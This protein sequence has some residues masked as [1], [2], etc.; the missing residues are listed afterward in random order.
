V[1]YQLKDKVLDTISDIITS[2]N[3]DAY[4][5]GGYVRD[6]ILNRPSKDIDIVTVG[7]GIDLAT[8]TAKKLDRSINVTVFKNFGTAMFRYKD[9]EYEFV[10]ARKESYERNSRKPFVEDGTLQDDQNRRDLTINALALSLK[11]SNFGEITDPFNGLDDLKNKIIKTPLDPNITFSDDPLR[12][13]RAIRF[14]SQLNFYIEP[15]TFKAIQV[16]KERINI[17][18]KER[19]AEE[20]NKILLSPKPSIGFKLLEECELLEIIFPEFLKLKGVDSVGTISHKD[21]FYHTLQVVDNISNNTNNLWLRWAALLHDIGKPA[22]KKFV[23]GAWTFYGHEVVGAKM[24]PDIFKRLKLPL[25]ETVKY[26]QKLINLHLR[27]IV[28]SSEEVT[29]SAIRRLLFDA[30]DEVDD[31]MLLCEADITS[32]N[33]EKV[34]RFLENFKI[35]RQKLKEVEERDAM[36]NW[37]PPIN[38][39]LIMKEFN[40]QP[41][42]LVGEIKDEIK[43]AILDGNIENN[44]DA[45]FNLLL[46]IA[47][48]YGLKRV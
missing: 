33:D 1:F 19:I 4:I 29:D 22:T 16:N 25:N 32:K 37:K 13:M 14:A 26:L 8:S 44:F 18:S 15:N 40:L 6:L 21:N 31:L 47:E 20:L 35:V 23:N 43:D 11:K 28:L 30:G 10:G 45:A 46:K 5:I 24:V 34:Q 39:E 36:R 42:R 27:P 38:G 9:I 48:K 17:I 12:M 7:S 41:C 3:S 2:N